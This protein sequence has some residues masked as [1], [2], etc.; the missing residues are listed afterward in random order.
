MMDN[1]TSGHSLKGAE[2]IFSS[3]GYESSAQKRLPQVF[4]STLLM[5]GVSAEF[6]GLCNRLPSQIHARMLSQGLGNQQ[7]LL[8]LITP[9]FPRTL[10]TFPMVQG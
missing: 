8:H 6:A 10:A 7:I 2:L 4:A 5:T 3:M 9:S 1:E